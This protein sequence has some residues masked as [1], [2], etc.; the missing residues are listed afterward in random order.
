[1]GERAEPGRL[2]AVRETAHRPR[3]RW[4]CAHALSK[5]APEPTDLGRVGA[6]DWLV[7]TRW[8]CA[9]S[10]VPDTPDLDP[11]APLQFVINEAAGGQPAQAL[12][13]TIESVLRSEG[14]RGDFHCGSPARLP[15]MAQAAAR[16]ALGARSAVIGVGGDG[17]LST[18]ARAAHL[19]GCILGVLPLGTFNYFARTHQIPS[20]PTQ[21]LRMLLY[22]KPVQVPVAGV[23]NR[24]FLVN[25]SLGLYPELL[26]N[27]EAFTAR[28]GRSRGVALGAAAVTL[29]RAQ[30]HLRLSI[31]QEGFVRKV[32]ALTL[33]VGSSPLQLQRLGFESPDPQ[34]VDESPERIT[35]VILRP[36]G[37]LAMIGL[38]LR[39]AMGTLGT[40][41]SVERFQFRRMVVGLSR[42]LG[43]RQ[44]KVA[45]DGEVA[46]M[47]APL[48]FRVMSTPL[49]LLRPPRPGVTPRQPTAAAAAKAGP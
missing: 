36:V 38:M 17:T 47:R 25:A 12:R 3:R 33:F 21:A 18:V 14:R 20:D 26:E 46:S 6:P 34:D 44:V 10:T 13:E 27:R 7:A 8:H 28:F 40:A 9:A 42:P 22:A 23:N 19:L 24:I 32:R 30:R 29:L 2:A 39:G 1:M 43:R 15:A 35:A 41:D 31:E 16:Q 37:A 49:Y 45:F 48:E 5:N 4:D 11:S